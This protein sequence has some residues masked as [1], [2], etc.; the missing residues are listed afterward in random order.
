[1]AREGQALGA[2]LV[3]R[4]DVRPFEE[5]HIVLLKAFADQAAIA[6]ENARLFRAEQ[7]RSQELTEALQQQ[8]AT[9]EVLQVISSSPSDLEPVFA[10]MLQNA[11]HICDAKR[12]R[13]VRGCAHSSRRDEA[14]QKGQVR[15]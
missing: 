6:I 13:P 15:S 10:T 11:V 9:S 7:H 8:T 4:T 14:D 12:N 3:R 5:T 1:L 2:I